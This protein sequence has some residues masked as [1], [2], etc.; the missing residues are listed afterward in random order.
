[1][2]AKK[3]FSNIHIDSQSYPI[4]KGCNYGITS[5]IETNLHE[6]IYFLC[7]VIMKWGNP[8]YQFSMTPQKKSSYEGMCRPNLTPIIY[9]RK[10]LIQV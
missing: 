8:L 4:L 1:M 3:Q 6:H 9:G 2:H 7:D 5:Q 10:L